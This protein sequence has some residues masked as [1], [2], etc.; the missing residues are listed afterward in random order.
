MNDHLDRKYWTE[1]FDIT[2]DDLNR[3][4]NRMKREKNASTLT[5]ISKRVI[6]G[7][8]LYGRDQSPTIEMG[9][10][11]ANVRLW[12]PGDLWQVG[13]RAI[14]L[15]NYQ[16]PPL[17]LGEV[18]EVYQESVK[19][20]VDGFDL[21]LIELQTA[22]PYS[23]NAIKWAK[24][25]EDKYTE[26][27]DA[28]DER[29]TNESVELVFLDQGTLIVK[30]IKRALEA[31]MRFVALEDQ[32]FITDCLFALSDKQIIDLFLE[33]QKV[34][35]EV[36]ISEILPL[37]RPPIPQNDIGLFSLYV[38]IQNNG[39]DYFENIGTPVWPK[40]I[41]IKQPPPRWQDALGAYY[42]Y[43]PLTYAILL[44]PGEPLQETVA[45]RLNELGFYAD[46][47]QPKE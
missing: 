5:E 30:R 1:E 28:L 3:I 9:V 11:V 13:D 24:K 17:V 12:D 44:R 43:D 31:D 34:G 26:Y 20:K 29:D 14:L 18:R 4:F 35:K 22:P 8:L 45:N 27:R 32:W 23:P 7:R 16:D 2:Q 6:R 36:T 42:V 39:V 21:R 46:V 41:A 38:S 10:E 40:W 25:V 47:V 33:V 15:T 19:F 37:V